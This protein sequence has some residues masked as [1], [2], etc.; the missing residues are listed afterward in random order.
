LRIKILLQIIAL[1]A[2]ENSLNPPFSRTNFN[3]AY[4]KRVTLEDQLVKSIKSTK[5]SIDKHTIAKRVIFVKDRENPHRRLLIESI[6]IGEEESSFK[7]PNPN[8]SDPPDINS[9]LFKNKKPV[10]R[11]S[12]NKGKQENNRPTEIRASEDTIVSEDILVSKETLM[13]ENSSS[14]G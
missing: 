2:I 6:K 9:L 13:I 5:T 11:K 4:D 1:I 8:S 14:K 7:I 3:R 12:V 10:T